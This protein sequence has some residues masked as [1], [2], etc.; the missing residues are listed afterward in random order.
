MKNYEK[1]IIKNNSIGFIGIVVLIIGGIFWIATSR[2]QNISTP[3]TPQAKSRVQVLINAKAPEASF[4]NLNDAKIKLSSFKGKKVMLWLVATWCS[5]CS[6]GARVLS[7]NENAL[8]NLTIITLKTYNNAGYPGPSIKTFAQQSAPKMLLVKNWLW[9]D[10]TQ[11]SASV[12]NPRNYPDIYFLIDK[13][14]IVRDINDAPA[15]TIN[16]IRAFAQKPD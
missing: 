8:S 4:T 13:N 15:A 16:T 3:V 6:E 2:Q 7:Q 1:N 14:G 5:S 12:Y 11:D 10:I 9:G